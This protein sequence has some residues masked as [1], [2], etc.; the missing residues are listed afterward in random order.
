MDLRSDDLV[1]YPEHV[2]AEN[3]HQAW[4]ALKVERAR[5][6]FMARTGLRREQVG[7]VVSRKTGKVFMQW[8]G[9]IPDNMAGAPGP[10]CRKWV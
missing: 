3:A 7:M 4:S 2:T 1:D 5:R 9:A 6:Q 10:S 8:V